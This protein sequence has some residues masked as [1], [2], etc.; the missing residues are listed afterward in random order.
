M[1]FR[2]GAAKTFSSI[3]DFNQFTWQLHLLAF[4]IYFVYFYIDSHTWLFLLSVTVYL[5]V[6]FIFKPA[7]RFLKQYAVKAGKTFYS[8]IAGT[9]A[10]LL[11]W[12]FPLFSIRIFHGSGFRTEMLV[13]IFLCWYLV[14]IVYT[15]SNRLHREKINIMRLTGRFADIRKHFYRTIGMIPV[16]GKKKNPFM[17]LDG[18]SFNIETGMFGLLG[19]N[20]AGKTTIMR[21]ICGIYDLSRGTI[22]VNNIN[23]KN[24]REEMLGL[25]GYLPQ[26]FGFYEN[27]TAYEFLDYIAILKNIFDRKKRD[28]LINYTLNSVHLNKQKNRR[29]G[30][31]SGGMKQRLG[32]AMILLNLPRI[33]V[34]DEPTAGLDPRERI[35]FRNLMVELSKERIVIF[36]TH[37]IED[38][39]SSCNKLA[40]LDKGKLYY[41]GEPQKMTEAAE[42]KVWQ[43]NLDYNEFNKVREKLWIVH[44][45]QADGSIRVRCLS[46]T[47]P[48]P[49]AETA[50][51]SLE[52]A[53][54][55]LLGN[56]S[57]KTEDIH[58]E[59]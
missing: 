10:G 47:K 5:Y 48:L 13:F 27:M 45:M 49:G 22:S 9:A 25:I 41:L 54:L 20:G 44:H 17:A 55:W 32:I 43:V 18:A 30:E 24:R 35:R 23:F 58:G 31:F 11:L 1:L 53:Y 52:D 2:S 6:L 36:S 46:E 34:V 26:E 50:K 16:I 21:I 4:M 28:Y 56:R 33:L 15:T 12:G 38:I 59:N 39:S 7:V 40:V 14:L 8:L 37:I 51:P 3:K 57:V 19:P 42:G 29:I